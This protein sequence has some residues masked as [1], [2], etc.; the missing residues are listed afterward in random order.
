MVVLS[1]RYAVW[2]TGERLQWF[3]EKNLA[4]MATICSFWLS[5]VFLSPQ[6]CFHRLK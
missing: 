4:R 3:L 2:K 5:R 1:W 6:V